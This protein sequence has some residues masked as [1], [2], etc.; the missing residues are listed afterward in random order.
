MGGKFE[1][2]Q[3]LA[4]VFGNALGNAIVYQAAKPGAIQQQEVESLIPN[5]RGFYDARL[6][7]GQTH[8]QAM[9]SHLPIGH[10]Q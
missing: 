5:E 2:T 4:D 3:V 9:E 6:A 1:S 10:L 8:A 7:N